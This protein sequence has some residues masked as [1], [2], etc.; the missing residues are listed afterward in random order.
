MIDPLW[1]PTEVRAEITQV[2]RKTADSVTLV[3]RPNSN[4]QGFRAG[5]FVR[6]SVDIDRCVEPG[7]TRR[8]TRSSA[9]TVSSS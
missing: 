9:A 2:T 7:A 8:R 1:S 3:L 4:W 5:Q 6:L